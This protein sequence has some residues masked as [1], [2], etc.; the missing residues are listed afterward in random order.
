V[1]DK[2]ALSW[3]EVGELERLRQYRRDHFGVIC[4]FGHHTRFRDLLKDPNDTSTAA[5][6]C[7]RCEVERLT[8]LL[9]GSG[10]TGGPV[11]RG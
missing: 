3:D 8:A 2:R 9:E 4:R 1:G 11:R 7:L 5:H 10:T 6:A